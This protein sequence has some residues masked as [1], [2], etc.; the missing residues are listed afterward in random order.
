MPDP[1][2]TWGYGFVQMPPPLPPAAPLIH[3]I[4]QRGPDRLTVTWL[5][6]SNQGG[7]PVTAYDLR[8]IEARADPA[9]DA[10]WTVMNGVWPSG[11]GA[12]EYV[13]TGIR[14]GD[15]Y[16]VQ[17]RAVN[18][19]GTGAWSSDTIGTTLPAVIPG[20]PDGADRRGVRERGQG[21]PVLGPACLHRRGPDHQL[22]GR[23][24]R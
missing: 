13:I 14:G 10:N 21:R 15:V 6:S 9:V 2:N 4:A 20:A 23:V 17:M 12:R 24:V 5:F 11:S 3:P 1:N 22:P 7:G 19:W 18:V 8:Y 16:R